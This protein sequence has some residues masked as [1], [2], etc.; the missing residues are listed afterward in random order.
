[1]NIIFVGLILALLGT[2]PLWPHSA[3][4]GYYPSIGVGF[5]LLVLLLLRAS[6]YA[7]I[8]RGIGLEMWLEKAQRHA[9]ENRGSKDSNQ[10][11]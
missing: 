10:R 1:M 9:P 6:D 11:V 5:V 2:L 8:T 3:T 4:W 7:V